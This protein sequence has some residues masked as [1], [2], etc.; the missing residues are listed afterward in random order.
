MRI[1]DDMTLLDIQ[2]AFN[3]TFPFLKVEFYKG[4][5]DSGQGSPVRTQL[6]AKQP[7]AKVRRVHNEGELAISTGM[8]VAELEQAFQDRYGLNAQVFRKSGNLWMQTT[9]TDNWTLGEQNRK[10]GS[11]EKI[12]SE[13]YG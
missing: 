9:A 7:L 10:G 11:S 13:K 5:H 8:T 4:T 6:D 12:F 2:I 3:Q 1:A